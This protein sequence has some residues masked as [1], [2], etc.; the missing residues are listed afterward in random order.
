LGILLQNS[1]LEYNPVLFDEA[2]Y[3]LFL[4]K[5]KLCD[6]IRFRIPPAPELAGGG[7]VPRPLFLEG[8][9]G[10]PEFI[11]LGLEVNLTLRHS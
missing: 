4:L 8:I 10:S 7:V 6:E 1:V 9:T 11:G 3:N 5:S 2:V